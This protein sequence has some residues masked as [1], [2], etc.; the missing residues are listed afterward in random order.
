MAYGKRNGDDLSEAPMSVWFASTVRAEKMGIPLQ[1]HWS[2]Q[3]IPILLNVYEAIDFVHNTYRN[4]EPDGA[5]A[6]AAHLFSRAYVTNLRY[7]SSVDDGVYDEI[8]KELRMYMGRALRL[9][10]EALSKPGGAMRDDILA[11]VWILANY[12]VRCAD[13][14]CL[15]G[16][17]LLIIDRSSL[18]RFQHEQVRL[19]FQSVPGTFTLR[20]CIAF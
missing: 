19:H 16:L 5:L 15:V 13:T 3:S 14:K 17:C 2:S 9:I 11:T 6:C 20:A 8:N 1:E 10:S 7:S 18:E 12:E 4:A